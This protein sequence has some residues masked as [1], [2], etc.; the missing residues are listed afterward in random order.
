MWNF[1]DALI[2]GPALGVGPDSVG[3]GLA[4]CVPVVEGVWVGIAA[5]VGAGSGET[6]AVG[7]PSR[8]TGTVRAFTQTASA[9]TSTIPPSTEPNSSGLNREPFSRPRK[10]VQRLC[11]VGSVTRPD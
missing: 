3:S 10:D 8:C 11:G 9:A 4:A 7:R 2:V 1:P 5:V 6:E